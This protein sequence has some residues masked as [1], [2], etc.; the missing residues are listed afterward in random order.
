M[1]EVLSFIGILAL[2]VIA[3]KILSAILG[4]IYEF[5]KM[6]RLWKAFSKTFKIDERYADTNGVCCTNVAKDDK[7]ISLQNQIYVI[8]DQVNL[9]IHQSNKK[10][11]K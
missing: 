11:K 5:Y 10:G 9:L 2:L 7:V 6:K 4:E 8:Q 1:C 3:T